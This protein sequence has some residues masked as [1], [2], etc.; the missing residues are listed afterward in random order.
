M[1]ASEMIK[2]PN[3]RKSLKNDKWTNERTN[4]KLDL[5]LFYNCFCDD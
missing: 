5:P 2:L 4:E 1:R 3:R